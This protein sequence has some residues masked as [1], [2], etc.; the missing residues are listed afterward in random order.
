MIKKQERKFRQN[1]DEFHYVMIR[2]L[3]SHNSQPSDFG[4]R[5]FLAQDPGG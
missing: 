3:A 2:H 4:N 1:E 5:D